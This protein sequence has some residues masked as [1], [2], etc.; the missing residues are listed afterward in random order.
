[1]NSDLKETLKRANKFY[2][3]GKDSHKE[4]LIMMYSFLSE[5]D[6]VIADTGIRKL[7]PSWGF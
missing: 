3:S 5:E 4:N 6:Q 2:Q 1:M 7:I